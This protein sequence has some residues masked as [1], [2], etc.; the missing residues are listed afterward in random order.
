MQFAFDAMASG[1]TYGM[2][3]AIIADD[4]T[5][6]QLDCVL[7]TDVGDTG[8]ADGADPGGPLFA[9]ADEHASTATV[10]E[11]GVPPVFIRSSPQSPKGAGVAVD[12]RRSLHPETRAQSRAPLIASAKPRR[13]GGS[14]ITA[15]DKTEPL[16]RR[17]CRWS[18]R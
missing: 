13:S 9:P 1:A 17:R 12:F 11:V 3:D 10:P 4:G 6:V 5:A 15:F 7:S 14:D 2:D 16:R 18:D 8:G